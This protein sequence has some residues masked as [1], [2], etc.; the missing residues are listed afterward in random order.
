MVLLPDPDELVRTSQHGHVSQAEEAGA[1]E[2]L[3]RCRE[4]AFGRKAPPSWLV[5][6]LDLLGGEIEGAK[7]LYPR[8]VGSLCGKKRGGGGANKRKKLMI[9]F[10]PGTLSTPAFFGDATLWEEGQKAFHRRC[11]RVTPLA[12]KVTLHITGIFVFFES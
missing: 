5:Y 4:W 2:A 12:R 10:G 7:S 11:W 1:H 6:G 3:V 8:S 9:G